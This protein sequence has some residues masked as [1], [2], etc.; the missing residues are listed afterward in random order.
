MMVHHVHVRI[1]QW[2]LMLVVRDQL[3]DQRMGV[4]ESY[5]TMLHNLC[6][7][8]WIFFYQNRLFSLPSKMDISGNKISCWSNADLKLDNV[9]K[10]LI[11]LIAKRFLDSYSPIKFFIEVVKKSGCNLIV[12][13]IIT[14]CI[15]DLSLQTLFSLSIA[16]SRVVH[17]CATVI[18]NIM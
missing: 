3:Y 7:R 11:M 9:I 4:T 18:I 5:G 8:C 15:E 16:T 2:F 10:L 13:S 17:V 6:G 14:L 12:C 1:Q